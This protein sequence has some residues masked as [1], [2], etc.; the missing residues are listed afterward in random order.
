M[1]IF[2]KIW[3][4]MTIPQIQKINEIPFTVL[5]RTSR[6]IG[7]ENFGDAEGV[8]IELVKNSYD[9]DASVSLV[10][11]DPDS[12]TMLIFD[13]GDGMKEGIVKKNSLSNFIQFN[14]YV[15]YK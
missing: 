4:L 12:K 1:I 14:N 13:N 5:A 8:A 15:D 6:L 3:A 2:E 10:I 9:Y 11:V 7:K